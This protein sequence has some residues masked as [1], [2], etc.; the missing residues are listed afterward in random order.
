MNPVKR[1]RIGV[2][3]TVCVL[4]DQ[5]G[6]HCSVGLFPI[7]AYLELR[8][9]EDGVLSSA[10]PGALAVVHAAGPAANLAFSLAICGLSLALVGEGGLVPSL[11]FH[12]PALAASFVSALSIAIGLYNLVPIPPLDGGHLLLATLRAVGGIRSLPNNESWIIRL[13]LVVNI[14]ASVLFLSLVAVDLLSRG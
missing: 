12:L 6:T 7:A 3:P 4:S 8:G 1:I 11:D 13:G 14:A 9:D 10:K 5:S 2:G